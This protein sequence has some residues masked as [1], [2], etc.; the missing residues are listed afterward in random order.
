MIA[1]DWGTSSLRA[2]RLDDTGAVC[3]RTAAPLGIMQVTGGAFAQALE[4]QIGDWLRAGE[5]RILMSGMIGAR[6]G[7]VEAPYCECPAGFP[8]I[9][10]HLRTVAW[11]TEGEAIATIPRG[12]YL[13]PL[14]TGAILGDPRAMPA[15]S[16]AGR[17]A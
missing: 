11:G 10:A 6:Q 9:A 1:V 13:R 7:W 14:F 17:R 5:T 15:S 4:S 16:G 3:A 2:Y 12:F 8:Q